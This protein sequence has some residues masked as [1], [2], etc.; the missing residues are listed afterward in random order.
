MNYDEYYQIIE[1]HFDNC[2]NTEDEKLKGK[3]K[4]SLLNWY[5]RTYEEKAKEACI[6]KNDDILISISNDIESVCSKPDYIKLK[7]TYKDDSYEYAKMIS[8]QIFEIV[9]KSINKNSFDFSQEQYNNYLEILKRVGSSISE[10]YKD[11]YKWLL[12]ESELDLNFLLNK[13][14]VEEFSFRTKDYL[15]IQTKHSSS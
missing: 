9:Q 8:F 7:L 6:N 5:K 10:L 13:G 3:I 1:N 11:D 2:I 14:N 4:H 12:S 15:P